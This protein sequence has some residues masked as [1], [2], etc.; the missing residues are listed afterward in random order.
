MILLPDTDAE[1]AQ[2][3]AERLR[4]SVRDSRYEEGVRVTVSIGAS[5]HHADIESLERWIEFADGALYLAKEKGR[6]RV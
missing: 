1:E 3:F 4:S 6:D 5:R 2:T